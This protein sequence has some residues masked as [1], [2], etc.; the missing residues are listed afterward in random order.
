[1]TVQELVRELF[2]RR[3]PDALVVTVTHNKLAKRALVRP[4]TTPFW[5]GSF[6]QCAGWRWPRAS[7]HGCLS[8]TLPQPPVD[9][10]T[11]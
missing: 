3:W 10:Q 2:G 11:I 5:H 4:W 1:M 8:Q 7:I 6:L 9:S